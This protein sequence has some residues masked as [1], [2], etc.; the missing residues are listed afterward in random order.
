MEPET[1][2]TKRFFAP[3]QPS[4]TDGSVERDVFVC[5][6]SV[7]IDELMGES[8]DEKDILVVYESEGGEQL[9]DFHGGTPM[10]ENFRIQVLASDNPILGRFKR[11]FAQLVLSQPKANRL[12]IASGPTGVYN[13]D[14]RGFAAEWIVQ[15]KT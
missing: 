8:W 7:Q 4:W 9:V 2:L 10:T 14:I 3:V 1:Y 11:R 12:R 6:L 15:V 13:E 5:P